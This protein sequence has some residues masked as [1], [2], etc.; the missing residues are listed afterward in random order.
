MKSK[1][2]E[3]K[4]IVLSLASLPQSKQQKILNSLSDED[5]AQL[6]YAWPFWRRDSQ[7]F[8]DTDWLVGFALA[9]RG[10]GKTRIGAEWVREQIETGKRRVALVGR[11]AKDVRD[12]MVEGES[13]ILNICP[14]WNRPTYNPSKARITWPNGAIATCYSGDKPDS[15]RGPQHDAAWIDELAAFRYARDTWDNLQL[16]LRLGRLPQ[17][18]ITTTPRPIKLLREILKD[19]NTVKIG[20]STYENLPNLS[21]QFQTVIKRYEGTT[22][23]RQELYAELLEDIP[24]ALWRHTLIDRDRVRSAPEMARIVVA[25]DPSVT[26]N[27]D[28]DDTGIIIAGLGEDSDYYIIDDVSA[29]DTPNVWAKRAIRAFEK[30]KADRIVAEVN[31]GGDLVETV[32]RTIQK[33]ISYRSLHA[34]RGKR[35]RAE[36]IAALYEQG[37]VH[38][39]G[40]FAEL[41]DQMCTWLPGDDSPDR[42]DAVVWALTELHEAGQAVTAASVDMSMGDRYG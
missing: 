29:H 19:E 33:D 38:H 17:T 5:H 32:L 24:G 9:G 26:S 15:L 13:G 18:V 11:T 8:P 42:M 31:N 3:S 20:G 7:C 35:T 22:R 16:G 6:R 10:F 34:S 1:I 12:V 25:I 4:S 37:R 36:P 2:T 14:P 41:E 39:I 40:A 21:R 27:E 23:G 28:S 30:H